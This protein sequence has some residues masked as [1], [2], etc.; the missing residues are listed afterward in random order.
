MLTNL[1]RTALKN[2]IIARG[3]NSNPDTSDGNL[4]I[5]QAYLAL[6]SPDYFIFR[7]FVPEG[8]IYETI[9]A[10]A[11]FWDWTQ[12]I[13]Q[14]Q[15]EQGAWRQ[16]VSMRGGLKPALKNVR[17]GWAK[18][19][20]G[21]GA[22]PTAQRAHLASIARRQANIA[23]KLFAVATAGGSGTRGS[24]ANPDTNAFDVGAG[25]LMVSLDDI[26]DARENG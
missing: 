24:T 21:V 18:I 17:D 7:S 15:T 16:M 11:T 12:Y 1:Q 5:Q 13:S 3:L 26:A 19:F 22:G 23:E 2:D 9:T 14:S 20:S 8:D 6:A 25:V 10:D 4:V